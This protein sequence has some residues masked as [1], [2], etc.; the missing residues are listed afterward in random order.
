MRYLLDQN[1]LKRSKICTDLS[2]IS[3]SSLESTHEIKDTLTHSSL[4][5][6]EK[7]KKV[8]TNLAKP[9]SSFKSKPSEDIVRGVYRQ[10]PNP[11]FMNTK[12]KKAK[13]SDHN[14][15]K[16]RDVK[17]NAKVETTQVDVHDESFIKSG[18][19]LQQNLVK[20]ELKDQDHSQNY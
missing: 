2:D 14:K 13:K 1:K 15:V 3:D 4:K 6:D 9:V 19:R 20:D 7:S 12:I 5:H 11:D 16:K 17:Q 8:H 10:K 18:G